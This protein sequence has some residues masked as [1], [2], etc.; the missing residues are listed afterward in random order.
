MHRVGETLLIHQPPPLA[1]SWGA[2]GVSPEMGGSGV[3]GVDV[4]QARSAARA[5]GSEDRG[6]H[7]VAR[8][9][10]CDT[11]DTPPAAADDDD[12]AGASMAL[13]RLY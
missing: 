13:L 10:T 7:R 6:A 11:S 12:T 4:G 5:G 8:G 2:A 3:S 9:S 1:R